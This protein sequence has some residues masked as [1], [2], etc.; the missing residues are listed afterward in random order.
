MESVINSDVT[1]NDTTVNL[2]GNCHEISLLT[3]NL[4]GLDD[5]SLVARTR[6]AIK[7]INNE[8]TDI[9]FLQEVV[10][11]SWDIIQRDTQMLYHSIKAC[12]DSR[13]FTAVLLKK[14]TVLLDKQE[15]KPFPLST[16]S[17]KLQI[18][19]ANVKGVDVKL[20]TSHLESTAAHAAERLRQFRMCMNEITGT[21]PNVNVIFGGDLNLGARDLTYVTLP[22]G[23]VDV[24]E[25]TGS[26]LEKKYTWDMKYNNN[27]QM[28]GGAT[29]RCRFDRVF[30]KAANNNQ[31]RPTEFH[32]KGLE[33]VQ[34][35]SRFP[36]DHWGILCKFH[37]NP[38]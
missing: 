12:S 5:V 27:K 16:M 22:V 33:R 24:W 10:A 37:I 8:C 25:A 14:G 20:L 21:S 28:T 17:R 18:V 9:V 15:V 6:A 11:I 4:D 7:L 3:W 19:S 34:D 2:P 13:Y 32:L 38:E 23:L 31:V 29:P 26:I 1:K 36:S 30:F 35:C